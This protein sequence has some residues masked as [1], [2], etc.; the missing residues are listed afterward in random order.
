MGGSPEGG[1]AAAG[2]NAQDVLHAWRDFECSF[3]AGALLARRC[4]SGASSRASAT[5]SRPA[6]RLELTPGG[7]HAPH[8]QGLAL[9]LLA[10]LRCLSARLPARGVP[11]QRHSAAVGQPG[12]GERSLPEL[13]GVPHDRRRARRRAGSQISVLRD[14]ERSLLYCCHS[15][16]AHDMAGNPHVLSVGVDLAP[17]LRLATASTRS[18][19]SSPSSASACTVAARRASRRPP[20]RC[21]RAVANVLN[22]AWIEDALAPAGAHHLPAQQP[23]P[24]TGALRGGAALTAREITDVRE[25]ILG[26]EP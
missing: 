26:R 11:R 5:A 24:A 19:S 13:G 9:S 18:E 2:M 7:R 15:L 20:R 12:A 22:I 1:S 21:S 3:F 25:E 10:F 8:D 14:G 6:R 17:A 16:R 4:R 23:L